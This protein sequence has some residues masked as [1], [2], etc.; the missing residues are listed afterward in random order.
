M[1][2]TIL[3]ISTR[4]NK[5][6]N[7]YWISRQLQK[8]LTPFSI[9]SPSHLLDSEQRTYQPHTEEAPI[10]L[11]LQFFVLTESDAISAYS[12]KERNDHPA[13]NF[14]KTA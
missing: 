4:N 10:L 11:M 9:K 12:N 8:E 5:M 6:A 14:V 7:G 13:H 3:T 1:A 2:T